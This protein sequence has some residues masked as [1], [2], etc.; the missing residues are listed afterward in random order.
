MD[1]AARRLDNRARRLM[2]RIGDHAKAGTARFDLP[3]SI[4]GDLKIAIAYDR[5][6]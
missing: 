6:C 5:I 1:V 4:G 2:H 3:S